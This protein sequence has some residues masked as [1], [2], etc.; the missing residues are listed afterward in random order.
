M[1]RPAFLLVFIPLMA[2]G[3]GAS[4]TWDGECVIDDTTID[5]Q[6]ELTVEGGE[7]SGDVVAGFDD[8]GYLVF[9]DGKITGSVKGN[10]LDLELDFENGAALSISAEQ[11]GDIVD[12]S[13]EN[14]S[15]D[16]ELELD[17]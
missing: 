15:G 6:L 17:R 5:M 3:G 12:G 8:A 1:S 13:C 10:T 11:D 9:A 2:C 14:E 7:A 4:G 16:G